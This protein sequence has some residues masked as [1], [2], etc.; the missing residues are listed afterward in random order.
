MKKKLISILAAITLVCVFS[1][2]VFATVPYNNTFKT[3]TSNNETAGGSYGQSGTG[4]STEVAFK[5]TQQIAWGATLSGQ[6]NYLY[7]GR[8]A[9]QSS[10]YQLTTTQ[11]NLTLNGDDSEYNP[12]NQL[13]DQYDIYYTFSVPGYSLQYY[14]TSPIAIIVY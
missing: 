3:L 12:N 6:I 7:L 5:L 2:T 4:S 13:Y 1:M 14:T 9:H 8:V 10:T 11:T